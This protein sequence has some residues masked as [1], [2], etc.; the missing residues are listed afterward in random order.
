MAEVHEK[1]VVVPG[2]FLGRDGKEGYGVYKDGDSMYANVLGILVKDASVVRIVPLS[3]RYIPKLNDKVI[4]KVVD[5]LMTGWRVDMNSPYTA[6]LTLKDATSE[7]V[8][9][10]ADLTQFYALGEYVFAKITNVTTQKLVDLSTRGPGLRKLQGGHVIS[11][12]P[13]KVP[14]IIG[15]EGSMVSLIKEATG[16]NLIVGQ[17]GLVW[18]DGDPQKVVVAVKAIKMIESLAHTSGLTEKVQSFLGKVN[19]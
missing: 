4:G 16:C 18:I 10:G 9:K 8:P 12:N 7:F 17:N 13:Q 15:K 19:K 14:R 3:G 5:V 6:V 2:E 1:Q 11:V